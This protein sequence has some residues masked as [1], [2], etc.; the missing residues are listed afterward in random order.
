MISLKGQLYRKER[1]SKMVI[2]P[3][4]DIKDGKCVRLRQGDFYTANIYY[5]DPTIVARMWADAGAS[6]IHVV[7]LDGAQKG[8]DAN[9]EVIGRI[10]E[11]VN[12]PVQTGGGVR[13]LEDIDK[14]L[15]KGVSRVILGTVAVENSGF[16]AEA[17]KGFGSDRIVV[18]I[19]AR[20]GM[21]AVRG[22]ESTSSVVALNLA[23]Q[24][25]EVGVKTV[26]YTDIAKD[27][28]LSGPNLSYT[29]K[30]VD[31]SGLSIIASGGV[32]GMRDLEDLAGI[33]AAGVIVGKSLYEKRI[34]LEDAI[35]TFEN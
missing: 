26:I 11:S 32:S 18:G 12:I 13:S 19:D 22:W 7:D 15:S 23:K 5:D 8:N 25:C 34:I 4:I 35:R 27:G 6:Y 3:A 1:E 9:L 24:M 31:E 2:Y 17:V 21:V 10:A 28:M 33:G 20:D 14:R 29:K 30:L 16:V